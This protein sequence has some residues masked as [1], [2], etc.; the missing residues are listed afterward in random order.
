MTAINLVLLQ[1]SPEVIV[2]RVNMGGD[3]Q[4]RL[5]VVL[6]VLSQHHE[7]GDAMDNAEKKELFGFYQV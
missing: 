7:L 2:Y 4:K 5:A 1:I 3:L 6:R